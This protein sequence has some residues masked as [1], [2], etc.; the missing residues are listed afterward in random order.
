MLGLISGMRQT[1]Y[2]TRQNMSMSQ[3]LLLHQ[4]DQERASLLKQKETDEVGL[5]KS[6]RKCLQSETNTLRAISDF[7]SIPMESLECVVKMAQD[8][9]S[10]SGQRNMDSNGQYELFQRSG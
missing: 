7:F 6:E 10:Q 1:G 8:K 3:I 2:P 9:D 5:P 4:L